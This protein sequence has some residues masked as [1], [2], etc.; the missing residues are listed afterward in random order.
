MRKIYIDEQELYKLYLTE[1]KS[2]EEVAIIFGCSI[3]VISNA[4]KKYKIKKP[5]K[6][7]E[8]LKK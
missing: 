1:N 2:R 3:S 7:I 8:E 4:I 6:L 5:Q